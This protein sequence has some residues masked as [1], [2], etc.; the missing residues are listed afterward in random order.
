M[1]IIGRVEQAPGAPRSWLGWLVSDCGPS[2]LGVGL[3]WLRRAGS[4][5]LERAPQGT[6]PRFH[7]RPQRGAVVAQRPVGDRVPVASLDGIVAALACAPGPLGTVRGGVGV[8]AGWETLDLG[9]GER[10]RRVLPGWP[11]RSA[12][13]AHRNRR[14]RPVVRDRFGEVICGQRD[15]RMH[16]V[17][18]DEPA[19]FVA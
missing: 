8:T 2:L 19:A 9:H 13:V 12:E 18:A 4:V 6:H 15:R 14:R 3:A 5:A 17:D 7:A 1:V 11:G 10:T 16:V